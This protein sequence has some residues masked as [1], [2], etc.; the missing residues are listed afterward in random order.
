MDPEIHITHSEEET[1]ELGRQFAERLRVGDV[2]AFYGGL[3]AGK[4][5]FVKGIC[6]YFDVSDIVSSP[7]FTIMNQYD[8]HGA[9]GDEVKLYHVDLYRINS[10]QEFDDIGFDDCMFS[11]NAIKMVEWAE[12]ANGSLPPSR[13]SVRF[14]LDDKDEYL[15]RIEIAHVGTFAVPGAAEV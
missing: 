3:G 15:R 12:K 10:Q 1:I 9:D 4:T 5:E 14:L 8:G 6:E 13:Y 7:T 2:V 11:H